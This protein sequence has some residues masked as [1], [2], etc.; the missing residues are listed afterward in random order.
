VRTNRVFYRLTR[1][2][3]RLP[4]TTK[5]FSRWGCRF[6]PEG[7]KKRSWTI[8]YYVLKTHG[9]VSWYG[10]SFYFFYFTLISADRSGR[11]VFARSNT[12]IVG[13]NPTEAWMFVCVLCAFFPFLQSQVRQPADLI[14][15]LMRT[16]HWISLFTSYTKSAN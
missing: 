14:K 3:T 7:G 12:A 4:L 6:K 16:Y 11:A 15:G 2:Y 1:W 13:S 5:R 10:D 8:K 9:S